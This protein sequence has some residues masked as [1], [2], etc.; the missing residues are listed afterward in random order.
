MDNE[1]K[2]IPSRPRTFSECSASGCYHGQGSNISNVVDSEEAARLAALPSQ[3][4]DDFIKKIPK[5][6]LHVHLDGSVR[7][8]TII[9]ISKEDKLELPDYT[10]EGLKKK[11]F[12]ENYADLVEYLECFKYSCAVMNSK[13]NIERISYEF[14]CD[15]YEENVVYFEVRFAPQLL[16]NR[17]MSMEEVLV[18]VN[19]GLSRAKLEHNKKLEDSGNPDKHPGFEY[20]IITTAMRFFDKNSSV[21]FADFLALH[22]HESGKRVQGLASMAL[23]TTAVSVKKRLGLPIV[24]IDIAGPEKGFPAVYHKDAFEY[25][26]KHFLS[27]TCHA[28]EAYGPESIFQACQE[29]Y[30]E[31]IGHGFHLFDEAMVKK[32]AVEAEDMTVSEYVS[33]LVDYVARN[34]VLLEVCLTSNRQTIPE[35][36]DTLGLHPFK[37]MLSERLSLSINTDNRTVSQTDVTNELTLAAKTFNLSPKEMKDIIL[38]SMKRS[39]YPR[40]YREKRAY[41]RNVID[42]YEKIEVEFGLDKVVNRPRPSIYE[43]DENSK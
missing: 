7:I 14:A 23:A 25:A 42:Y 12:K 16:A 17:E 26:H 1:K 40:V 3:I 18:A 22:P 33:G 32:E 4:P 20:G 19:E 38:G 43:F 9:D 35:L 13:K 5:V 11:V 30:A 34:R 21:Y 39:F 36:R 37:K 2:T 24:A 41:V 31:R 29:L 10:V 27:K 28:G 15:N 6:D 8:Q